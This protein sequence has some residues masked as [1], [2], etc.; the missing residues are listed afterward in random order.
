MCTNEPAG[1]PQPLVSINADPTRTARPPPRPTAPLGPGPHGTGRGPGA[2]LAAPRMNA[3]AARKGPPRQS[4]SLTVILGVRA[5]LREVDGRRSRNSPRPV[6][7]SLAL[8]CRGAAPQHRGPSAGRGPARPP[9][10]HL[11]TQPP[12][13]SP[14][15][16][17]V[18]SPERKSRPASRAPRWGG[19]CR[20]LRPFLRAGRT[21]PSRMAPGT[22]VLVPTTPV[23]SPRPCTSR[24]PALMSW[25]SDYP[26]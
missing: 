3:D 1:R 6:V 14:T 26:P 4:G 13:R 21:G 22:G 2:S 5:L 16:P 10:Q 11:L 9:A 12:R 24:R 17:E 23:G 19:A 15:N 8:R 7:L 18:S 25:R 20:G